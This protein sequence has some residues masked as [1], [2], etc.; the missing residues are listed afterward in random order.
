[1]DRVPGEIPCDAYGGYAKMVMILECNGKA[2]LVQHLC[3]YV[4]KAPY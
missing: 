1:M 4:N 3:D 2:F